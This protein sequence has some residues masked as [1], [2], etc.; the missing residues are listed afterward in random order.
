M[1]DRKGGLERR[2]RPERRAARDFERTRRR[3]EP[4]RDGRFFLHG[5]VATLE[6]DR[7]SRQLSLRVTVPACVMQSVTPVLLGSG[8]LDSYELHGPLSAWIPSVAEEGFADAAIEADPGVASRVNSALQECA[9]QSL[10]VFR[11]A[12]EVLKFPGDA[13]PVLPMGT[14]VRFRYRCGADALGEAL[15]KLVPMREAGIPELRFALASALAEA[16]AEWDH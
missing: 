5:S 16:L 7:A 13:V 6:R 11:A 15:S 2:P 10:E 14:Y 8:L 9:R 4:G 3:R 12:A 1:A